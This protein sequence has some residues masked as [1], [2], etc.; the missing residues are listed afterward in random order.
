MENKP[1]NWFIGARLRLDTES[2]PFHR[3]T[4]TPDDFKPAKSLSFN[5]LV[6]DRTDALKAVNAFFDEYEELINDQT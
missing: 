4:A 5:G 2:F 6:K 1:L 3:N